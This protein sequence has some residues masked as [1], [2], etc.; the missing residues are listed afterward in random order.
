MNGSAVIQPEHDFVSSHLCD[1]QAKTEN[2]IMCFI[3]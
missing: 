1:P 2:F 3:C